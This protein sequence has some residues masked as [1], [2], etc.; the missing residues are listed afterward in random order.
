MT[1]TVHPARALRV[2]LVL[3]IAWTGCGNPSTPGLGAAP[4]AAPVADRADS[5]TIVLSKYYTSRNYRRW[6]ER[7]SLADATDRGPLRFVQAYG[8][9]DAALALE[10][11]RASAIV[12]TG[13]EDIHPARYGQ[14]ADTV[15]CG[16]IDT[17]RDRVEHLLLDFTMREG[18]PCLGVCRGLQVMNVHAGG[19]LRPHLPDDG[20]EGHRGGT[21][22]ATRDTLHGVFVSTEW[23]AGPNLFA[24]GQMANVVSH[25][26]QGIGMLA[27]GYQAWAL[28]PDSL[29]E[30]IRWADTAQVPFLV[31]VQWHPE[32][33][34][35][36]MVL[37]DGLG[38]ALLGAMKP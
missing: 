38:R 29:I 25:H 28:S 10:L 3:S 8:M 20:F 2:L 30:G 17:E 24:L 21:P 27:D 37:T 14:P 4:A 35:T 19:T 9:E 7:L 18:T 33:S 13:G 36:G 32:R 22:G 11:S 1:S 15:R 34:D 26:H 12:L 5:T 6:L 31:G 23:A 16:S